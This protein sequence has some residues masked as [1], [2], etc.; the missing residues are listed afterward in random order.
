[1]ERPEPLRAIEVPSNFTDVLYLTD[2]SGMPSEIK[3]LLRLKELSYHILP[4]ERF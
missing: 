2:Q 1:M 4:I 3:R